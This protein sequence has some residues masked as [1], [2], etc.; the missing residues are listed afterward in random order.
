MSDYIFDVEFPSF[1]VGS[2]SEF[3]V[4]CYA[5]FPTIRLFARSIHKY[6]SCSTEAFILA[7]IYLDRLIQRNNFL[8]THL[9]AHRVIISAVL[10]AAKFFDDAYYNNAY[11]AKVGGVTV[12]E[13]NS[14][15]VEF[16]FRINFSLRVSPELYRK[17]HEELLSHAV[18]T[19]SSEEVAAMLSAAANVDR[20]A[21]LAAALSGK[22]RYD[23]DAMVNGSSI[24]MPFVPQAP[25]VIMHPFSSMG[26]LG[27]MNVE[28]TKD[29]EHN[30][31][32]PSSSSPSP[33]HPFYGQGQ[34]FAAGSV[35]NMQQM[36]KSFPSVS[37]KYVSNLA[38]QL[39]HHHL[40][41][42]NATFP[43]RSVS[44][45]VSI[46]DAVESAALLYHQQQ[47]QKIPLVPH[48]F[49]GYNSSSSASTPSLVQTNESCINHGYPLRYRH[50][51]P[52][53][54][55]HQQPHVVESV[56]VTGTGN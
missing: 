48:H 18:A 10:V 3:V 30:I 12:S 43:P 45:T 40:M 33:H 41:H 31:I 19:N 51:L 47:R 9:N 5:Y 46:C 34:Q 4:I 21:S 36:Q 55:H 38:A 54:H 13:L 17:Y 1:F 11:Y 16:L 7:L 53:Q 22:G 8:L 27:M 20:A 32:T 23:D 42:Q 6:A 28:P 26:N 44:E 37:D 50:S 39:H 2:P 24:Y 25:L 52:Q 49:T 15:E 56:Y 35:H 29:M 14:L